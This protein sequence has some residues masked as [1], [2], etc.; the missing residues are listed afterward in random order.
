MPKGRRGARPRP[1]RVAAGRA[2]AAR[3]HVRRVQ[4][5]S[6][7]NALWGTEALADG[8][9]GPGAR[10]LRGRNGSRLAA[11]RVLKE[12]IVCLLGYF[13]LYSRDA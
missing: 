4:R 11:V 12:G 13:C 7:G 9:H 10:V 8:G 6:V 2:E 1:G 5:D 3:V